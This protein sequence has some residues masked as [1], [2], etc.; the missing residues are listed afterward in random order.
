MVHQVTSW[1]LTRAGVSHNSNFEDMS[2][3]FASGRHNL[4]MDATKRIV[5]PAFRHFV[6][7]RHVN[8]VVTLW[9]QEGDV[10]FHIGEGGFM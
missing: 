1:R 10:S 8:A 6:V 3:A 9:T 4:L 5:A 2:N 7:Q